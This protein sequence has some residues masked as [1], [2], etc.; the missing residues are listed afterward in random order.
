MLPAPHSKPYYPQTLDQGMQ[1]GFLWGGAH[2]W[3]SLCTTRNHGKAMQVATLV[4]TCAVN[5][6]HNV[7]K[8]ARNIV[9]L[10]RMGTGLVCK[11]K[12]E[13]VDT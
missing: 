5:I 9:S 3:C 13:R 4:H 8:H 11:E 1:T 7:L 2:H 10:G 12:L 6:Q